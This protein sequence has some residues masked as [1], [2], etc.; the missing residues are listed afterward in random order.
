M[1]D[2]LPRPARR[3]WL[4]WVLGAILLLVVLPLAG[5]AVFLATFDPAS[6][7]PRIEAAVQAATGRALTLAGP[8]GLKLA[9]VPT[10]TLE[11]VTLANAPG[12]SRP[13]MARIRRVEVELA[14]LPLLSRQVEVKRLVLQAPD[15]LLETDAE[16]RPNWAFTPAAPPA[17]GTP[18][19]PAPAAA[20]AT[21]AQEAGRRLGIAVDR[22]AVTEGRL[23]WRDGRTGQSRLLEIARLETRADGATGPLDLSGQ[24]ALDG[25]P[26][27]LEGRTGSLAALTDPAAGSPNVGPWPLRLTLEAAGAKLAAEGTIAQPLQARGW[28][29]AVKA[30]IPELQRLAPLLPDAP[31]PPLR[32]LLLVANA[33]DGGLGALP[34]LSD[35]RLTLGPAALDALLPGLQLASLTASLPAQDQPLTLAAEATLSGVP[36]RLGGT[37]GAPALLLAGTPQPFPLDLTLSAATATAALKGTVAD[38]RERTGFDLALVLRVPELAA[39]AP[40]AGRPLPAVRDIALDTRIAER[41]PGFA[42]GAFLRGLRLTSSAADAVA[43]L[44]YVVGQ[45]QGLAGTFTAGRIDL[46]ALRPPQAAPAAPA[47]PAAPPPPRDRRVIPDLALPLEALRVTDSD[48]RGKIGTLFTSG[49]TIKDV[50]LALVVQDGRAR[51]DP[52]TATLPGG[53]ISLRAA[54]DVTTTPP[55]VQVAA[56]SEGLDLPPLLAA[57]HLPQGTTGRAEFD[58]DLRGQGGTLR[59]VAATAAGHVGLGLTSA[60]LD[61]GS[62]GPLAK[63][64]GDLRR[65]LPQLGNLAEGKIG[66]ACLANRWAVEGGIGRVQALLL[67]T[68]IGRIG[69]AGT[70]NLRDETLAMQLNLDLRLPIPGVNA[71]RIRA[72]VPLGGT[73]AQPRPE[74]AAVAA[75]GLLGTAE[76]LLRSPGNLADGLL[77]ALGGPQGV[78]PGAGGAIPDCA[79]ALHASRG[80]RA[81][82]VPASAVP[83]NPA[84]AAPSSNGAPANNPTQE[85]LRGLFGRGR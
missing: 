78:V 30:R 52:F 82:P 31:L 71:L 14:L 34:A 77:G 62:G 65:G 58:I 51:L 68:T 6:Q 15:I 21:A 29:M 41:G 75:S 19:T 47:G 61:Q 33:A 79:T 69:G 42:A 66:I 7:K 38:L 50:N 80:G 32:D 17:A 49:V 37:L 22:I 26:F 8:I 3:R 72:P 11:D 70:A 43:E 46:D 56:L 23:T 63:L 59:A 24:F 48:L 40:L 16:G 85:L 13:E 81:G 10:V 28:R 4:R 5:A 84:P 36:L 44:T 53:P 20:P 25:T 54:A 35:L 60:Q 45:R 57:L 1:S 55:T 73:F 64:F 2:A 27:T 9:L 67:D 83:S 76:G 18:A 39:L 12:G 74:F